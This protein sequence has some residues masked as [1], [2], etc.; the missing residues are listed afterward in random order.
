MKNIIFVFLC[1]FLRTAAASCDATK[2]QMEMT[3]C[4]GQEYTEQDKKLNA[5]FSAYRNRL[6]DSQKKQLKNAQLAW[7]KFRDLSCD[8]ESSA[9]EGGSTYRM[10][11]YGC[12]TQKTTARLQEIIQLNSCNE[13]D[14][15][16]PV[17]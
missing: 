7:I 4:A 6:S 17:H 3:V 14:L 2:S 1:I 16:C 12:L 5:A 11:L 15:S 8:F 10:V 13:G 9:V